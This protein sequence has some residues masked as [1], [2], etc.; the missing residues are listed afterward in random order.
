MRGLRT[1][2]VDWSGAKNGSQRKI[3]LAEAARERLLTL[4]NGRDRDELAKHLI[5]EA[6]RTPS[7]VVGLDFAFSFPAWFLQHRN[8][9]TP[10]DIWKAASLEGERWLTECAWPFWGRPGRKKPDNLPESFRCTELETPAIAGIRPKSVFQIGGAGAVGTG[11]I[12]GMAVLHKLRTRGF[13]IWPFDAFRL[14]AIVEIYPRVLTK[15]VVKTRQDERARYLSQAFPSVRGPF[16]A[17]AVG[18]EDAFDAAVSA[19]VMARHVD[20]LAALAAASDERNRL[21][22]SIW[23]QPW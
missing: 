16:R 11:S 15:S 13:S 1:L 4:E 14:P 3:W 23:Y 22:G 7:L 8:W 17:A 9:R 6:E 5:R 10:V 19:L 21:E 12:R 18:S 20:A 2:A